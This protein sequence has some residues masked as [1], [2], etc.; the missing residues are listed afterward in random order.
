LVAK[1]YT[2]TY[3]KD[4]QEFFA[5]VVEM[6]IVRILLSIAV[7]QSWTLHQMDVKN[8]LLRNIRKIC[9]HDHTIQSQERN[10][11]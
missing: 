2:Q 3:D 8:I 11:L 4:Y 7:N 1:D 9:I 6:N 5:L 10:E